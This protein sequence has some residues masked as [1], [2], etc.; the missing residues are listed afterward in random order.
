M[1]L[2]KGWFEKVSDV[3]FFEKF[4]HNIRDFVNIWQKSRG[5]REYRNCIFGL[6]GVRT[7]VTLNVI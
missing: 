2:F 4:R 5:C 7:C 6:L 3:L 1:D